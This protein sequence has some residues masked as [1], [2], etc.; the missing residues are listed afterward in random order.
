MGGKIRLGF[1]GIKYDPNMQMDVV[2]MLEENL[3]DKNG[4]HLMLVCSG[5]V[6]V[7][8]TLVQTAA[9][10]EGRSVQIMMGS[11][12]AEDQSET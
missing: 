1:L 8:L 5:E 2:E 11:T 10:K 7:P 12:F 4:R 3:R 6:N 9:Q